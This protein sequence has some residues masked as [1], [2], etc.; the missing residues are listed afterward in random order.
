[1]SFDIVT[2]SPDGEHFIYISLTLFHL[3][4]LDRGPSLPSRPPLLFLF[5]LG[6]ADSLLLL[7]GPAWGWSSV[8][9]PRNPA[10]CEWVDSGELN[11]DD[12]F[13]SAKGLLHRLVL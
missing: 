11:I 3:P 4:R 1:M 6:P 13:P 9:P 2:V 5:P 12:G 7:C 8:D 10:R